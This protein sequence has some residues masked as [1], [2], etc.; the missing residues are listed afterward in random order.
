MNAGFENFLPLFE[1]TPT[2][3]VKQKNKKILVMESVPILISDLF[4]LCWSID[5]N[6]FSLSGSLECKRVIA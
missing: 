6:F 3:K 5:N 1:S 2:K 4:E